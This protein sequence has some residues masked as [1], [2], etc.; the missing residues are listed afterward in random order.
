[1]WRSAV[2]GT[3]Q[4]FEGRVDSLITMM[5]KVQVVISSGPQEPK[6]LMLGLSMAAS[7]AASGTNVS[8]FLVMD[9]VQCLL[10][11]VCNKELLT[12]YPPV[13]ELLSVVSQTGGAVEYC[14]HCIPAG[15]SGSIAK[16]VD[17]SE[18]SC[19]C[20]GIP[21]GIASYGVRLAECPTVVF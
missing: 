15:C 8:L 11:E 19:G 12:G 6:R 1:M 14:P 2:S 17:L 7:A 20:V 3:G 5:N 16:P 10:D 4:P 9:G 18:S 21:A 13:A